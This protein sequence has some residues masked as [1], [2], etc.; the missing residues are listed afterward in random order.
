MD[1]FGLWIGEEIG[2]LGVLGVSFSE[3]F[4]SY[5]VRKSVE[6][7]VNSRSCVFVYSWERLNLGPFER[8]LIS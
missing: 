5:S 3:L 6:R 8:K 1:V 2:A 4:P 7:Y